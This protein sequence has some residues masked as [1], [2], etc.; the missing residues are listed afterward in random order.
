GVRLDIG[1]RYLLTFLDRMPPVSR[2][3]DLGCGTGILAAMYSR[4]NPAARVIATDQSA[5][6]VASAK[7]T[8]AANGLRER[9]EVVH[10]DA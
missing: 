4:R 3:V 10:D 6:A 9:I 7:E 5:A 1:T 2:V 8:L